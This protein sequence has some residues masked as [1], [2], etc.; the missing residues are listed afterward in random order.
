VTGR[1]REEEATIVAGPTPGVVL[2]TAAG[3][4]TLRCSGLAESLRFP[5]VPAD[6]SAKP[7]LSVTTTTPVART[8]TVTL[9]YL[10]SG[11]DWSA[12]YVA[13]VA[14]DGR[15]LDLFAW[16]TL[17]NG[18]PETFATADVQAVAGR[19]NRTSF[20]AIQRQAGELRLACYPLGTTTSDLREQQLPIFEDIVV[21]GSRMVAMEMMAPP[22]PAPAAPPAPPPPPPEDLGDLKLY[23][24]PERVTVAPRAQKQ[25]ALLARAGVPFDRR[26]RL[27][28]YPG[29]PLAA[30]PMP[31]VLEMRNVKER[32][33]GLALPTG[34]TTLYAER[35]GTALLVGQGT[36]PDQAEG[37]TVRVTAG[38]ST[39]VHVDQRSTE[40]GTSVLTIANANAFP[41]T[42][43][44]PIGGAG[45]KISGDGL[46]AV[47]GVAT[48]TVTVPPGGSS[49]LTY[50][51]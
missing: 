32:G 3:I 9:S 6:L 48:W 31:I 42:A 21:T 50:R 29:Q 18:N 24:V 41:I 15:T 12:S 35:Q 39:Q 40:R 27:P 49:M 20:A 22:P 8:A 19:L 1:R 4:E 36:L 13:R 38:V 28:V 44:L 34:T 17:A 14:A 2:R 7:V 47:D 30:A 51:Y 33:L 10:T 37:E 43:V 23:R 45:Q 46:V 11:F 16:L 25:V 26:Y 5:R